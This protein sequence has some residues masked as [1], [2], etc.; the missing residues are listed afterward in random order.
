MRLGVLGCAS[1]WHE[2]LLSAGFD[3]VGY[4]RDDSE[5]QA[6]A[7]TS[8][9]CVEKIVD[10]WDA[11]EHPRL[12]FLDIEIGAGFD[13]FIDDV[14]QYMEPGDILLDP[15]GS[16]WCDTLRRYRRMRHRSLY[17]IDLAWIQREN[18]T[19]LISGDKRGIDLAMPFFQKWTE[20]KT[21]S[22][23]GGSG[24]AHY[25]QMI[26]EALINVVD[27]AQNEAAQM[28]EA[29]PSLI[30]DQV[31]KEVFPLSITQ[32]WNGLPGRSMMHFNCK[33]QHH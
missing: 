24:L 11:L 29:W 27:Q 1:N 26:N 12:Y 25:M 20:G 32:D 4:G 3:V 14:Y 5:T 10:F 16:Y 15:S 31:A 8:T 19:L 30:D 23:V 13:Q 22:V 21:L 7:Q 18:P 2:R 33:P 17:Y 9:E 28:L 6:F